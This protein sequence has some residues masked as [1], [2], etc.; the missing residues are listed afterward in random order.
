[1]EQTKAAPQKEEKANAVEK[2]LQKLLRAQEN[3]DIETFASCFI[4]NNQVVHIGTDSDEYFTSWR[5]YFH[6]VEDVL[7]SRQG[8]E[9]NEKATRIN[10]SQDGHT[11]WFS[12][13]LDTC[14]ETR[15]ETTR[16]DGFRHTGVLINTSEGW[17][18]VQSHISAPVE[19]IT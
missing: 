17:K 7:M 6:W 11:A 19:T 4:H 3:G 13:L 12:Q 2:V 14:Y 9:I 10:I 15:G 18:I 5:D 16:I 1:M 8:Q